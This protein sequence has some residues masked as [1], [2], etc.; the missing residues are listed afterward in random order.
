MALISLPNE[1]LCHIFSREEISIADLGRL[2]LTC[3]RFWNVIRGSNE[4]W[5]QKFLS[6]YIC[7]FI[8]ILSPFCNEFLTTVLRAKERKKGGFWWERHL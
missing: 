3:K 6:R 8:I 2:M 4:L 5:K 7:F 1:V